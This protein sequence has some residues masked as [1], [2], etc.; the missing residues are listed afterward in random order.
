MK[1][2]DSG[3]RTV[4][5]NYT[6]FALNDRL[7][8]QL[9]KFPDAS[10]AD[11]ALV[12]GYIDPEK[13]MMFEI[14]AAAVNE[15]GRFHFFSGHSALHECI[16]AKEVEDCEFFWFADADESLYHRYQLKVDK[17]KRFSSNEGIETT[18]YMTFLDAHRDPY[19]IDEVMVELRRDGLKPEICRVRITGLEK[20]WILG[21]LKEEP[22]Q[23]FGYH[24][25]ENIVFFV[26]NKEGGVILYSDMT[27]SMKLKA[28]DLADGSM[29]KN[30][31][32]AF[33]KERSQSH[34]IDVLEFLRDSYVWVPC[35]ALLSPA[36]E[37]RMKQ[38]IEDAK[39]SGQSLK[40]KGFKNNDPIK[41]VPVLLEKD[42]K[43]LFPV[44]SDASEPGDFG[45][46]ITKVRKHI[47]EVIPAARQNEIKV[48]GIVLNPY[49]GAF[50]LE[51][52]L[53]DLIEQMKS[54]LPL[55]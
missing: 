43:F 2:R 6:A 32:G 44:Q 23:N 14:L 31:V 28:E 15:N 12:Y 16:S 29:L 10:K 4:Y 33:L 53:F 19:M 48:D 1:L 46:G 22:K 13:G 41:L 5:K 3:F 38:M 37:A 55:Q 11:H 24:K 18:R 17:L 40:G 21:V 49:S 26:Q 50:V 35:R 25:D 8:E 30:A 20:R 9:A 27:P 52:R 39:S 45:R 54:R 51:A 34:F 42:G 47:L 36:D 7:R